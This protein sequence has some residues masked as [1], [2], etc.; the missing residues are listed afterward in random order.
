MFSKTLLTTAAA[1]GFIAAA[2]ALAQEATSAPAPA[3]ATTAAA[4]AAA[5]S[6]T[7]GAKVSDAQGGAVGTV[8]SVAPGAATVDT[9]TVKVGVPLQSFAAGPNG[10]VL[11]MTKAQLEAAAQT[12]KASVEVAVGDSVS[13]PSGAPVGKIEAVDADLVTLATANSKAR[14]P[15]ASFSNGA[16]GLVIGMTAAQ[17]DEASKGAT[18]DTAAKPTPGASN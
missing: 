8:V 7:A 12:A 16:N 18:A 15:K 10:L 13:D 14:L 11:G 6:V 4:P 17:I 5:P 9:G 3:A 1:I 2:P